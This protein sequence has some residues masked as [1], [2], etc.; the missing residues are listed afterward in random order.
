MP[1]E[2][3][4]YLILQSAL[5]KLDLLLRDTLYS[6]EEIHYGVSGLNYYRYECEPEDRSCLCCSECEQDCLDA[7]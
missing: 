6:L 1:F 3:T 7:I 4:V 5:G 2:I